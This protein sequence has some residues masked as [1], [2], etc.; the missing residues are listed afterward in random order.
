MAADKIFIH[1]NTSIIQSEVLAHRL[2][3]IPINADPRMFEYRQ[4]GWY[5]CDVG[6]KRDKDLKTKPS[7]TYS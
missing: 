2:G 7:H 6:D 3:L 4:E 5:K 1:N